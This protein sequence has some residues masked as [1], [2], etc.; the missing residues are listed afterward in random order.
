M[1]ALT[2][3]ALFF[4]SLLWGQDTLIGNPGCTLAWDYPADQQQHVATFPFWIDGSWTY[5]AKPGDRRVSCDAL[6]L[7]EPGTYALELFAKAKFDS[8]WANSDRVK[9]AIEIQA[10]KPKPRVAAPQTL[11]IE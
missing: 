6:G 5:A 10:V 4:P 3:A 2:I 8:G 11:R 7:I 9:R 1:R